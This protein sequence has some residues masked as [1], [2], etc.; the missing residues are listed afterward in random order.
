MYKGV[1]SVLCRLLTV[2]ARAGALFGETYH[3]EHDFSE[4]KSSQYRSYA[5]ER[6]VV[7][8]M[9]GSAILTEV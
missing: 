5:R 7:V 1:A 9:S 8:Y 3:E 2:V 4:V 6:N